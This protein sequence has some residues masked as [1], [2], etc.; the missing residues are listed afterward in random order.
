MARLSGR[1]KWTMVGHSREI[2]LLPATGTNLLE[3]PALV[4]GTLTG[5]LRCCLLISTQK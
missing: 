3:D 2:R 1:W 4:A 5:L